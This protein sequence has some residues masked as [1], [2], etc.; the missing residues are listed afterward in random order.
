MVVKQ[1]LGET[2]G[3]GEEVDAPSFTLDIEGSWVKE[4]V[5]AIVGEGNDVEAPSFSVV[6]FRGRFFATCVFEALRFIPAP[7]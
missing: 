6:L 4:G 3:E 7:T 5:V 2:W 1:D